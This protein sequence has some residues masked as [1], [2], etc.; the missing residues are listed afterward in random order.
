VLYV[1]TL[2]TKIA[3]PVLGPAPGLARYDRLTA[4]LAPEV[5]LNTG[6]VLARHHCRPGDRANQRITEHETSSTGRHAN[7]D[8]SHDQADGCCGDP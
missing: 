8:R 6:A 1:V 5:D 2:S 7:P 3:N 4:A